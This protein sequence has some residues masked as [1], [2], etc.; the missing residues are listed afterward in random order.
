MHCLVAASAM[1]SYTGYITCDIQVPKLVIE[2]S[3][4]EFAFFSH[5]HAHNEQ[6][7]L[8]R[9]DSLPH[10]HRPALMLSVS[11][12]LPSFRLFNLATLTISTFVIYAL[13]S[14]LRLLHE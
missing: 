7:E 8:A 11:L 12:L 14:S 6:N 2:Q 3:V 13:N 4:I 1:T 9:C 5:E 10:R